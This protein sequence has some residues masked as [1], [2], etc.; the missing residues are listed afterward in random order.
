MPD[1]INNSFTF[2]VNMGIKI[3]YRAFSLYLEYMGIEY[4]GII[5]PITHSNLQ[6][7][8]PTEFS[9]V[10]NGSFRGIFTVYKTTWQSTLLE[11]DLL[12]SEIGKKIYNYY[13]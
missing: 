13:E 7:G 11:N 3:K 10:L 4:I 12:V 2:G 8:L 5:T 6:K 1:Q 9:V